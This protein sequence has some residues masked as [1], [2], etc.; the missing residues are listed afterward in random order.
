MTEANKRV[1]EHPPGFRWMMLLL[2][3]LAYGQFFLTVQVP[4]AFSSYIM[5]DLGLNATKTSLFY[6]I[7]MFMFAVTG[8]ACAK[9]ADKFGLRKAVALGI[10]VNIIGSLLIPVIGKSF[11]GYA[12]CCAIQGLCGGILCS[13]MVSSTALWFPVRQRGLASGILLGILGVGFS[14]ATFFAPRLI[15]AGFSWQMGACLIS[16]V[17]AVII[18]ILYYVFARQVNEVYPGNTS[19]AE[20]L[21]E[22]K[23]EKSSEKVASDLPKTMSELTHTKM[24]WFA[25][26]CAFV[27]GCM[28][29]GF[30]AFVNGL[31]V[32]DKGLDPALATMVTSI[33]FFVTIFGSPLGGIISDQI[34]KGSRWQTVSLS[35]SLI[36]VML[37]IVV[38]TNGMPLVVA[39]ILAY[40]SVSM[41][42]GPYWAVPPVLGDPAIANDASGIINVFGNL[43]GCTIGFVLT[44]LASAAG[45]Y[46]ICLYVTIALAI[47]GAISMTFVKR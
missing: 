22:E 6:T 14:I 28:S 20:M 19:V 45:N 25:S 1:L 34:F 42:T 39:M 32:Q 44:A 9:L 18:M 36:A 26:I 35:L 16:L 5:E 38:L 47:L 3:V 46:F 29:Y 21:P 12:V 43:G 2:N 23:K 24:F 37:V 27:N 7:I 41:V 8:S 13:N 15:A 10:L 11:I 33:T 31:L 40:L 17:P 30:P 4:V